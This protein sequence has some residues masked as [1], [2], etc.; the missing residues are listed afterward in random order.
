MP[1]KSRE[2]LPLPGQKNQRALPPEL[3]LKM[4]PPTASR[5]PV[6]KTMLP[7]RTLRQRPQK[8]KLR[9]RQL[10]LRSTMPAGK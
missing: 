4:L 7:Q 2:C 9:L 5:L 3:F 6:S 8:A 10:S 1:V